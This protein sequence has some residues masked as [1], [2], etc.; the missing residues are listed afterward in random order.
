MAEAPA[1]EVIEHTADIGVR[2]YGCTLARAFENA[3]LGMFS[4]M[5][6]LSQVQTSQERAIEVQARDR[7]GLLVAWLSELLYIF[8][9]EHLVFRRFVVRE[10]NDRYL[11]A[12][13]WGEP[14][15]PERHEPGLGVKAITRH[16]LLVEETEK[17]YRV[18]VI[19]D[20]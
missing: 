5:V 19:L 3:A 9:V 12:I 13:A 18:Q 2:A 4:L 17:G 14:F 15:D 1:F 11:R 6:P 16:M 8:D 20:I 10:I 7:E